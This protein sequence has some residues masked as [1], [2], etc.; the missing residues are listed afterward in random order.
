M[1]C[2]STKLYGCD[3][4]S[5]ILRGSQFRIETV[6]MCTTKKLNYILLSASRIQVAH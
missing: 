2:E 3:F 5:M 4:E 1:G 6:L